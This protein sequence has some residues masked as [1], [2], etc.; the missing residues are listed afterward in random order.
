MIPEN[1]LTGT[2]YT[3]DGV[4]LGMVTAIE[5]EVSS[6]GTCA[7]IRCYTPNGWSGMRDNKPISRADRRKHIAKKIRVEV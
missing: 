6:I 1:I 5:Y 2:L 7:T 4:A 3:E